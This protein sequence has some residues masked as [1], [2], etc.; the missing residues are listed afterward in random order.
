M[1]PVQPMEAEPP[2][3]SWIRRKAGS[4]PQC[5]AAKPPTLYGPKEFALGFRRKRIYSCSRFKQTEFE[6]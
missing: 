5:T 4:F 6:R 2:E 3:I 1:P